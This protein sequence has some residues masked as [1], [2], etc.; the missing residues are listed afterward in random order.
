MFFLS[1]NV[2]FYTNITI[3]SDSLFLDGK[4]LL[5]CSNKNDFRW[6][7]TDIENILI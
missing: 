5:I 6:S 1:F 2:T 4:V 3:I 7:G